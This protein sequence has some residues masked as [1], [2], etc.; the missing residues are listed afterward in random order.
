MIV[1]SIMKSIV[2]EQVVCD[3]V[4]DTLCQEEKFQLVGRDSGKAFGRV[5]VLHKLYESFRQYLYV[6][7]ALARHPAEQ[8]V[9]CPFTVCGLSRE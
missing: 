5:V 2:T 3:Y 6:N 9:C 8:S 1:Q 4:I 7:V